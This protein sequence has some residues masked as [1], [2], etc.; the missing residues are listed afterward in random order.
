MSDLF[1]VGFE[2]GWECTGEG[3]NADYR[4]IWI[5]GCERSAP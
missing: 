2:Q 5:P 1:V 3:F 4:Q